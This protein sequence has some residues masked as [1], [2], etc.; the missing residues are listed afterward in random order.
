MAVKLELCLVCE[1][2]MMK[3]EN[4]AYSTVWSLIDKLGNEMVADLVDPKDI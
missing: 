4:S 3:E 1:K 2:G